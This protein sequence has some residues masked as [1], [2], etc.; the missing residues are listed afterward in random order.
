M[1]Y[2]LANIVLAIIWL[3]LTGNFNEVNFLFGFVFSY[4]IL[5][6]LVPRTE[7]RLY[8]KKVFKSISFLFYFLFELLKANL[9]VAYDIIT[10]HH[11][12]KPGILA[13]PLDAK[14]GLEITI[15]S[16]VVTLTPGTLSMDVSDDRMVMYIHFMYIYNEKDARDQIKNFEK[17]IIEILR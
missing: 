12:M 2:F 3:I 7:S 10:P 17:K 1:K 6:L 9:R 15:L 11:H 5:W 8:F 16:N 13:V 4:F 14:S